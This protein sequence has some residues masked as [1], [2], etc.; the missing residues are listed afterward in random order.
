MRS[1]GPCLCGD[2]WCPSCGSAMGT[3]PGT[4]TPEPDP[5]AAYEEARQ[6]ATDAGEPWPP[7]PAGSP[8]VGGPTQPQPPP[9]PP[10]KG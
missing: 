4:G 7:A 8:I 5:D 1:Y 6:R 3:Y 10:D 9:Q 2:P